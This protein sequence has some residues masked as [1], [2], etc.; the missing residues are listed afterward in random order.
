MSLELIERDG[1][2][3]GFRGLDSKRSRDESSVTGGGR[4]VVF[5]SGEK[6]AENLNVISNF[7]TKMILMTF[8]K[9]DDHVTEIVILLQINRV[10][11]ECSVENLLSF[12]DV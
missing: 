1:N 2:G 10:R 7:K 4:I 9:N 6:P 11:P 8:E 3:V 5:F 12:F